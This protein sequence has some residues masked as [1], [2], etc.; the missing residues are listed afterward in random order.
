MIVPAVV[1]KVIGFKNGVNGRISPECQTNS[2][3]IHAQLDTGHTIDISMLS[4]NPSFS[5]SLF[6]FLAA[7]SEG[8]IKA[9]AVAKA[10]SELVFATD[11]S[12]NVQADIARLKQNGVKDQEARKQAFNNEAERLIREK[13]RIKAASIL[14]FAVASNGKGEYNSKSLQVSK[15]DKGNYKWGNGG[16]YFFAQNENH[17]PIEITPSG[18]Y[19]QINT[20]KLITAAQIHFLI[21]HSIRTA[22][23]C[24]DKGQKPFLIK[25]LPMRGM[26]K[27]FARISSNIANLIDRNKDGALPPDVVADA[28]CTALEELD[29]LLYNDRL[30]CKFFKCKLPIFY[31]KD[32]L[33][34]AIMVVGEQGSSPLQRL[35]SSLVDLN[36]SLENPDIKE[37]AREFVKNAICNLPEDKSYKI[38]AIYNF[39]APTI[40]GESDSWGFMINNISSSNFVLSLTD[41]KFL[42]ESVAQYI[43][44]IKQQQGE[45]QLY[46]S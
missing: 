40:L 24:I 17:L 22:K 31:N 33:I 13:R 29:A 32:D 46:A 15:D 28:Y 14:R 10:T 7:K 20:G 25:L 45:Q 23:A 27:D 30:Q 37:R 41:T 1:L 8:T 39:M 11:L 2:N 21:A 18:S 6:D 26:S 16:V 9:N 36:F 35:T 44:S 19:I 42:Y 3:I 4:T 38:H 43:N 5:T 12:P 34:N